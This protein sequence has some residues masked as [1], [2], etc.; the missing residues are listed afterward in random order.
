MS[1]YSRKALTAIPALLGI[2]LITGSFHLDPSPLGFVFLGFVFAFIG[3]GLFGAA[4][5]SR[6]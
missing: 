6:D 5:I 2:G 3:G 4:W 1:E